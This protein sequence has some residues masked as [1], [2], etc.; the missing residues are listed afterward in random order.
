MRFT[1]E[2]PHAAFPVLLFKNHGADLGS[3][4][5]AVYT[6]ILCYADFTSGG[7]H[8]SLSKLAI[9]A[10]ASTATVKRE[11]IR[12]EGF[13]LIRRIRSEVKT[14]PTEYLVVAWEPSMGLAHTELSSEGAKCLAHTEPQLGSHRATNNNHEDIPVTKT[15]KRAAVAKPPAAPPREVVRDLPPKQPSHPPTEEPLA[16]TPDLPPA[17]TR[18]PESPLQEA[19]RRALCPLVPDA[20]GLTKEEGKQCGYVAGYARQIEATPDEVRLFA[21]FRQRNKWRV[22]WMA[23]RDFF[24]DWVREYR[25]VPATPRSTGR[26]SLIE[27]DPYANIT[28]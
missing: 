11:L 10:G 25:S 9:T 6:A 2:N 5:I 23:Y 22:T 16:A 24:H 27:G 12:L 1:S 20:A 14:G 26:I 15:M 8:P 21:E 18:R 4:A 28:V 19:I 3:H 7:C 17:P 13:G